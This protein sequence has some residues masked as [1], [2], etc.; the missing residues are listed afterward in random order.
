MIEVSTKE[1]E[2]LLKSSLTPGKLE[3]FVE[4]CQSQDPG[5]QYEVKNEK[6]KVWDECI[7]IFN[8]N[9]GV[10]NVSPKML[11]TAIEFDLAISPYTGAPFEHKVPF[12]Q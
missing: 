3:L 2:Q 6:Q 1:I 10:D 9:A 5:V 11:L 7:D 4:K 12:Y 8:D